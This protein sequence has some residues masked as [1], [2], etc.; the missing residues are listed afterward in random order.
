MKCSPVVLTAIALLTAAAFT[1][2]P[3]QQPASAED[4]GDSHEILEENMGVLNTNYKKVRK[5][6]SKDPS[7]EDLVEAA[8]LLGEMVDAAN[9]SKKHMP[10]TASNDELKAKYRTIL[11]ITISNAALAENA[12]LAGDAEK[13]MDYAKAAYATKAD[14]HEVFIE[15]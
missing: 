15:E 1:L 13:A 3:A 9:T 10:E 5:L 11:N 7:A 6:L 14:G 8:G 2:L 4:K 12:A